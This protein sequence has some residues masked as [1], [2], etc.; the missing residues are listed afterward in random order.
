M[1]TFQKTVFNVLD[2]ADIVWRQFNNWEHR[3]NF[4]LPGSLID[5]NKDTG[6]HKLVT[7]I[8]QNLAVA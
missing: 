1:P 6:R 8:L 5:S 2:I 4:N 3:K 7:K